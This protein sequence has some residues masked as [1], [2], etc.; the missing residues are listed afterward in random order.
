MS[1]QMSRVISTKNGTED[2]TENKMIDNKIESGINNKIEGDKQE[3]EYAEKK[4]DAIVQKQIIHSS[5]VLVPPKET[6][7]M[8][9]TMAGTLAQSDALALQSVGSSL[10]ELDIRQAR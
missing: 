4:E 5:H 8:C 7:Q 6:E 2:G 3:I 9:I 1:N 10:L